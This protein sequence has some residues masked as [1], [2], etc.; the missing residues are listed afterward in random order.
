MKEWFYIKDNV[1]SGPFTIDELIGKVD[2]ET[3]VWKKGMDDWKNSKYVDELQHFSDSPP[4]VPDEQK[5]TEKRD[6]VFSRIVDSVY[7]GWVLTILVI[8]SAFLEILGDQKSLLYGIIMFFSVSG[9]VRILLGLKSYLSYFLNFNKANKNITWLII[10]IIPI[11]LANEFDRRGT[12]FDEFNEYIQLSLGIIFI[13]YLY[14]NIKLAIRLFQL[15]GTAISSFKGYAF[16]QIFMIGYLF[17]MMIYT[18][19][20]E[21]YVE[22]TTSIVFQSIIEFISY[23]F[24][25]VGFTQVRNK[26]IE[27]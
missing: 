3:L 4:P 15:N 12:S 2:G 25:L 6:K 16:M 10:T 19:L 8:A 9:L 14:H 21:S 26:Y 20:N 24:I 7:Y 18:G 27:N 13:L 22:G 17:S 1:K 5:V 23:I 11:F